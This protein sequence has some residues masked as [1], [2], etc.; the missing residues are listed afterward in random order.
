MHLV[1]FIIRIYH[2]ARSPE[3]QIRS[4]DSWF[5]DCVVLTYWPQQLTPEQ[6]LHS[7][8]IFANQIAGTVRCMAKGGGCYL[9]G[10]SHQTCS[11]DN[12]ADKLLGPKVARRMLCHVRSIMAPTFFNL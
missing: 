10:C 5:P 3:R 6:E 9:Q 1:G 8:M 11:V 4:Q 7:A 2:N 12:S